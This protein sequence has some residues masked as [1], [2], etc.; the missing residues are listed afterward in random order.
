M[1]SSNFLNIVVYHYSNDKQWYAVQKI[2]LNPD[3]HNRPEEILQFALFMET[4]IY[5][6]ISLLFGMSNFFSE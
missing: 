5:L 6:N 3:S 4:Q 2:R 1:P